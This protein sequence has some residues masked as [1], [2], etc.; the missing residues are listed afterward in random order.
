MRKWRF[1]SRARLGGRNDGALASDC[2][3]GAFRS[4][5]QRRK[6][7]LLLAVKYYSLAS[8][9][10]NGLD[11]LVVGLNISV[12]EQLKAMLPA[13]AVRSVRNAR[14]ALR[15]YLVRLRIWASVAWNLR[16][17]TAGDAR[18]L[19]RALRS[20]PRTALRDI[21]QWQFPMVK[22][23]CTV[24]AKGV[25]TFLVRAGTDDLFHALPRQEPAV[26]QAIR[27]RLRTG[28]VFI[29]AG[30]NIGF[31]TI[32]A[33]KLVG[34]EGR[35]VAVEMM[36]DTAQILREHVRL[37]QG[38]NVR[39]VEAALSDTAGQSVTASAPQGK[40]GQARIGQDASG[41]AV[42]VTTT[43][44]GDVIG[45]VPRVAV[46]KLDVEGVEIIALRGAGAAL[47]RIEAIVFE[48]WG[49][50]TDATQYLEQHGF[51]V[52]TLDGRNKLA[53]LGST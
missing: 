49:P 25:G 32:L 23:D 30:A 17:A 44:L 40:S 11:G 41:Q 22:E 39:V 43:T 36:P 10:A 52:E 12:R 34:A 2:A 38:T 33:S 6:S 53:V 28:D 31:Y 27:G 42:C 35:V 4:C 7:N 46:M 9:C 1:T 50:E 3:V 26:E 51:R 24:I 15:R 29:D 16:G 37:N 45:D 18:I 5:R 8:L 47:R 48:A 19:R 20:A 21:D 14:R 13:S